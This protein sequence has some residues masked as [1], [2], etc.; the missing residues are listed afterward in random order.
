MAA[1]LEELAG[2]EDAPAVTPRRMRTDT[3]L[4][5]TPMID[6][7]FLLLIFFTVGAT[8][9][10]PT[11]VEL[12]PARYGAGVDPD[13]TAVVTIAL[14][15]E[16]GAGLIHLGDGTGETP[17]E[18]DETAQSQAIRQY[19]E[20]SGK[21]AVMIKAERAVQHREISRVAET[22]GELEGVALYVAV[23]EAGE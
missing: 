9:E 1:W 10:S 20:A 6:C 15:D 5:M 4:D 14:R 17:L 7:T 13:K 23:L 3:E 18:G 8:I 22:I 12:P 16:A 11:A 19:V 21:Q 2:E